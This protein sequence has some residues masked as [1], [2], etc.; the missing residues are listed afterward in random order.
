[1]QRLIRVLLHGLSGP[2][3]LNG[4]TY[5]PLGVMPGLGQNPAIK[6]Q[7]I[8]DLATYIRA[9]W[10]NRSPQVEEKTVKEIRNAT[11]DRSAGQMYTQ[12]E[13]K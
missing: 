13:L 12:E 9:N 3:E 10:N 1:P 6:D 11:K 4:K 5:T 7:D 8:A 2:I